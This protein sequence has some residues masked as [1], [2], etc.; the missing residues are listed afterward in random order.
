MTE[1]RQAIDKFAT[2][3]KS[4][5]EAE[6]DESAVHIFVE[7]LHGIGVMLVAIKARVVDPT[8]AFVSFKELCDLE[9]ILAVPFHS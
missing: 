6:A 4:T 5:F 8:D 2:P 1:Q 9:G 7:I 3:F